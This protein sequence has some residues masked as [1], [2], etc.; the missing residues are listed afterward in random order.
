MSKQGCEAIMIW[1]ILSLLIGLAGLSFAVFAHLRN[2]KPKRLQYEV[3]SN[4]R[5]INPSSNYSPDLTVLLG[6][7]VLTRPHGIVVRVTNTGSIECKPD[8]FIAPL[9][10]T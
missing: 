1:T 3:L 7:T 4:Q 5:L 8:D 10:V 2:N 6:K 9:T